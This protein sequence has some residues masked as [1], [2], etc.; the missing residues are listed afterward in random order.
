MKKLALP[1][2]AL[3]AAASMTGCSFN[4]SAGGSKVKSAD[5]QTKV[6]TEIKAQT[7][8]DA[9]VSCPNDLEGKV[10]ATL[11]CTA[12]VGGKTYPVNINV[13][14]AKGTDV[15]YSWKLDTSGDTASQPSSQPPSSSPSSSKPSSA[16]PSSSPSSDGSSGTVTVSQQ[17]VENEIASAVRRE[18]GKEAG[19]DCP[20][21]LE[22][23]VGASMTCKLTVEGASAQQ[24]YTITVTRVEGKQ[25]YF[26]IKKA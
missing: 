23:R 7:G 8:K 3:V 5:V 11:V 24:D 9:T 15:K 22:G 13:T 6:A 26:D 21:P 2:A 19:V 17:N 14:E 4:F 16:R 1:A 10:G 25:V 12:A 20:G 18:T